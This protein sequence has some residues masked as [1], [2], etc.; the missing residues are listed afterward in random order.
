[1]FVPAGQAEAELKEF[2]PYYRKQFSVARFSQV[3]DD[4]EQHKEKITQL[5]RQRVCVPTC[6]LNRL[7]PARHSPTPTNQRFGCRSA[8]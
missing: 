8:G 2:G 1:M 6:R 5:L 4:L 3:E 7:P